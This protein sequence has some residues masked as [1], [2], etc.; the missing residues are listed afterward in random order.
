MKVSE[1]MARKL[2]T[3]A[4]DDTVEAA[5]RLL[6]QRGVRHLLV[7]KGGR[8]V[9]ILSDRDLKRAMDP[10][11]TK[12]RKLLN[13]G[14]L[15]FLLEPILVREIMTPDPVTVG[16]ELSA[17]EAAAIMVA[18]RFGALPVEEGGR[19]VGIVTETDLLRYFAKTGGPPPP[20]GE[21][22]PEEKKTGRQRQRRKG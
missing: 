20:E 13:V 11:K 22:R 12:K 15:F 7:I 21:N 10:G 3:V 6:R 8:L 14:G 16:P 9:G 19:T 18:E 2:F 5:V 4:P 1:L 17:Q